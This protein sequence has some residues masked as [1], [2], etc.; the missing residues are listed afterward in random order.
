MS[1]VVTIEPAVEPVSLDEFKAHA[2]IVTS[3][4]DLLLEQYI[5]SARKWTEEYL[6]KA[7]ITQTIVQRSDRFPSGDI[8]EFERGPVQSLTSIAY[9]DETEASQTLATTEYTLDPV[10]LNQRVFLSYNKT[11]PTT[12]THYNVVTLTYVAG[13]GATPESVPM[14]IRV[15]IMMLARHAEQHREA[16]SMFSVESLPFGVVSLISPYRAFRFS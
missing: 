5:I 2:R 3:N 12:L 14:P 1:I 7:L 11:W 10:P 16:T 4:E 9:K 15:A 13:Y 8:L 6:W